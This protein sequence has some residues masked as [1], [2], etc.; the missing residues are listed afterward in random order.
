M[1]A[2]GKSKIDVKLHISD[3]KPKKY[4]KTVRHWQFTTDSSPCRGISMMI[5]RRAPQTVNNCYIDR[6]VSS[7][8]SE[9]NNI[10]PM[11]LWLGFRPAQ[12]KNGLKWAGLQNGQKSRMRKEYG[13][14]VCRMSEILTN[15]VTLKVQLG[16]DYIA[17]TVRNRCRIDIEP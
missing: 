5:C 13:H 15:A 9:A 16:S 3:L 11:S 17:C 14:C 1:R 8:V 12:I 6:K 4:N 2:F 10:T 7:L